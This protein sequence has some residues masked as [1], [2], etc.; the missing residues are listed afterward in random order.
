MTVTVAVE[1]ED[2]VVGEVTVEAIVDPRDAARVDGTVMKTVPS[3][4]TMIHTDPPETRL[5]PQARP[6][7]GGVISGELDHRPLSLVM[8]Q[9]PPRARSRLASSTSNFIASSSSS[10]KLA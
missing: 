9:V 5:P 2:K 10:P 1:V 3:T 4:H 8:T 6:A 7:G